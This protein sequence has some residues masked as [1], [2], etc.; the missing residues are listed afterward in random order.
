MNRVVFVGDIHGKIDVIE[1]VEKKFPDYK[2]VFVGDIVDSFDRNIEDQKDSLN[3]V[4]HL[5]EVG[6]ARCIWGNHELSYFETGMRCTGFMPKMDEWLRT[7]KSEI[8]TRFEPYI[9]EDGL[10]VTHAGLTEYIWNMEKLTIDRLDGWL[11]GQ[12]FLHLYQ[13]KIGWIGRSR[14]G[15]DVVGGIYWCDIHEFRTVPGLKQVFGHSRISSIRIID[16][17][18][19]AID[20]LDKVYQVLVLEDGKFTVESL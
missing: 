20:C 4:L 8:Y 16:V 1:A 12:R 17:D 19:Y 6:R 2:Y 13:S 11:K 5:I 15:M 3:R 10:L 9:W 18:N 7:K 14:G